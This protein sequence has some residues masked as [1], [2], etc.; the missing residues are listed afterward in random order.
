M[1]G[2][3]VTKS[4]EIYRDRGKS[5]MDRDKLIADFQSELAKRSD[6]YFLET[7][8]MY[9]SDVVRP[10]S[11][12]NLSDLRE[13]ATYE[14]ELMH[15]EIWARSLALIVGLHNLIARDI[16]KGV[17]LR[18]DQRIDD[19]VA[20]INLISLQYG[21][22][23]YLSDPSIGRLEWLLIKDEGLKMHVVIGGPTPKFDG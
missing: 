23:V 6:E 5:K 8:N 16:Q 4:N 9:K 15:A 11:V 19:Y 12:W 1:C 2:R 20:A 14:V 10:D 17:D 18:S 21:V 3:T 22:L 13:K 7:F